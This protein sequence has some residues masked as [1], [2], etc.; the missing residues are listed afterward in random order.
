MLRRSAR[1]TVL[2]GL[3]GLRPAVGGALLASALGLGCD[4]PPSV[5]TPTEIFDP[6]PGHNFAAATGEVSIRAI[7][8]RTVCITTDGT[9]NVYASQGNCGLLGTESGRK[10][11]IYPGGDF[12]MAPL[13]P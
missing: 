2:W 1:A 11:G 9:N 8:D 5:P 7:T 3:G 6:R 4:A 12:S 10:V 13:Q